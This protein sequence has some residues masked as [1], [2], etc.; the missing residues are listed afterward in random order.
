MDI[1]WVIFFILVVLSVFNPKSTILKYLLIV[2]M[3]FFV[4]FRDNLG[5]DFENYRLIYDSLGKSLKEALLI[6]PL[7]GVIVVL[8]N[9]LGLSYAV[10]LFLI[11]LILLL[12]FKKSIEILRISNFYLSFVIFFCL[13]FL[14]FQFN[15]IRHGLMTILIYLG[16]GYYVE[17]RKTKSNFYLICGVLIQYLGILFFVI[18]KVLFKKFSLN[19]F[20]GLIIFAILLYI[21]SFMSI[22]LKVISS[23]PIIGGSISF[24]INDSSAESVGFSSTL[25]IYTI[26][27]L[28]LRG[29]VFQKTYCED[30]RILFLL[31]SLLFSVFFGLILNDFYVFVERICSTFNF[32]LVFLLSIIYSDYVKHP[33]SKAIVFGIILLYISLIL[34]NILQTPMPNK[35]TVK[36]YIPYKTTL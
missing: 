2:L 15:I 23:L 12:C 28:F 3:S 10:F 18:K 34:Y 32:S 17:G 13:F 27:S 35:Q 36:Q 5:A 11:S 8:C 24:Y 21:T 26:L 33:V 16:L 4:G 29:L 19:Q 7:F 1:Y 30:R 6:E 25:L 9:Y 14:Q 20:L 31:N 22:I